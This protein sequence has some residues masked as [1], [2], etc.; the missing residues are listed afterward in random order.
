MHDCPRHAVVRLTTGNSF[1]FKFK[2]RISFAASL[3]G[4]VLVVRNSFRISNFEDK[5]PCLDS[6]CFRLECRS[7]GGQESAQ[8]GPVKRNG[9]DDWRPLGRADR[10]TWWCTS[11]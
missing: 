8:A 3:Q 6:K 10:S 1:K 2:L 7:N 9:R 4:C 11:D 5:F